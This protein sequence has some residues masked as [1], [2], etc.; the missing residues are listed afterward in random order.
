MA[1]PF[2]TFGTAHLVAIGVTLCAALL[3]PLAVRRWID[4]AR[5]A[6]IGAGLAVFMVIHEIFRI[7]M[8]VAFLWMGRR[9][10]AAHLVRAPPRTQPSRDADQVV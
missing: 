9:G 2:V 10:V 3:I 5:Y 7:F 1:E 6:S 4:S 8:L